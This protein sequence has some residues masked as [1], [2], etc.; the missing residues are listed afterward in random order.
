MTVSTGSVQ[1]SVYG[2]D[3]STKLTTKIIMVRN[4][5]NIARRA[6]TKINLKIDKDGTTKTATT[7][8]SMKVVMKF[9][10]AM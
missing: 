9:A 2:L 1:G 7:N 6:T 4:N 5:T 10:T 3:T 8:A